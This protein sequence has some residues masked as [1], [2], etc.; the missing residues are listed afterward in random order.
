MLKKS[1]AIMLNTEIAEDM[2]LKGVVGMIDGAT[3]IKVPKNRLPAN[4]GFMV[5][6]PVATV[7]PVKLEDY[8]THQDPPGISGSLVEGRIVYDAFVLDNKTKAIYYQAVKAA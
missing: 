5:A 4:F 7:A 1:A 2:R 6:H 3:V 8:R